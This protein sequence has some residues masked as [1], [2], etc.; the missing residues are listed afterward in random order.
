MP[1][2]APFPR[3]TAVGTGRVID[4]A[5]I[6]AP[7]VLICFGQNSHAGANAVEEAVRERYPNAR[8]VLV[9]HVI[10]LRSVPRMFRKVAESVM[11]G[12]FEK[13]A[14][15]VP[16]GQA[17]EDYVLILPDWDGAMIKAAGFEEDVA[18]SLGVAVFDRGGRLVGVS[19]GADTAA[20]VMR[21]LEEAATATG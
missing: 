11:K 20:D 10:D 17:P 5:R 4:V 13:A 9:G 1:K 2:Q 6:E 19:Q 15:E 7:V 8:D 18:T 3:L 21:L 16:A 12:E 14:R